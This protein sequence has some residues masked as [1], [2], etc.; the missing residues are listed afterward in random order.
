M[1]FSLGLY[2]GLVEFCNFFFLTDRL[3]TSKI[4]HNKLAVHWLNLKTLFNLSPLHHWSI[5]GNL[6][7]GLMGNNKTETEMC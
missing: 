3:T 4:H 5:L 7:Q 1:G 2:L 6:S